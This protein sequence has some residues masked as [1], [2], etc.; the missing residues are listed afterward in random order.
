MTV[1]E[2]LT[3]I[4]ENAQ[5]VFDAG[6]QSVYET[7]VFTK[8]CANIYEAVTLLEEFISPSDKLV[9]FLNKGWRSLPTNETPDNQGLF[10]LWLGEELRPANEKRAVWMRFRDGAHSC[11]DN[12]NNSYSFVVPA[13]EEWVKVVFL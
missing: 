5:K 1:A 13:G 10:V 6:K 8:D 12:V 7:I 11:N 2:K 4:A 9:M 3:A